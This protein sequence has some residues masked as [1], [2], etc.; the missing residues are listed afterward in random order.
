M[1][2]VQKTKAE[3]ASATGASQATYLHAGIKH[4]LTSFAHLL[5][6][7]CVTEYKTKPT[8]TKAIEIW[9]RHLAAI[10]QPFA[11]DNDFDKIDLGVDECDSGA[12][13]AA[14]M[15]AL[16]VQMNAIKVSR[17]A[18]RGMNFFRRVSSSSNRVP[19]INLFDDFVTTMLARTG[20]TAWNDIAAR[21]HNDRAEVPDQYA[22]FMTKMPGLKKELSD[23]G[24]SV[25][26][27]AIPIGV[28]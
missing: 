7:Y 23:A 2:F 25:V 28:K 6:C 14:V 20:D 19:P 27:S 18:A 10:G 17:D 4:S 26:A 11:I 3:Y 21:L 15:G 22:K 16:R 24:F 9:E 13:G 8:K 5:F 12:K 1:P